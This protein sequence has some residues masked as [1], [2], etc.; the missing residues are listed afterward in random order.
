M[1]TS[2]D[3]TD[4]DFSQSIR[5]VS[6]GL[7][8]TPIL[9]NYLF[10]ASFPEFDLHFRKEEMERHPDNWFHPSTHP[11]WDA[12]ALYRYIAY[13]D[14]FPSEKKQYMNTLAVMFGKVWHE[15]TQMCLTDAGIMPRDL[16]QPEG[17]CPSCGP[18]SDCHEPYFED[19]VLGERGH[20]DGLLDL[21]RIS[22]VDDQWP[23]LE[24]KTS[25]DNFGRLNKIDDLDLAAF[26][27]KWPVYYAQQQRYLKQ[28]NRSRSIVVMIEP[29]FPYTMKEF[30]IPI[31]R[32][33]NANIDLTYATVRKA[34]ELGQE[35]TCC[36]M[37]GC[38]AHGLC[39]AIGQA[40]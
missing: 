24:I 40:R 8:V 14:T 5:Q 21:S 29:T 9:H 11:L 27:K 20:C 4:F 16:Q 10:D 17:Y 37:K 28:F 31:D 32:G 6:K 34:I 30:H 36:G 22:H 25:N 15:F 35:P 19:L 18:D 1:S 39:K 23:L 12:R 3:F 38:A 13:P 2:S 26:M 7:I 33:F